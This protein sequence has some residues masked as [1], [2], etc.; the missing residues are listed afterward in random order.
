M[1]GQIDPESFTVIRLFSGGL[2]LLLLIRFR[3]PQA[4]IRGS[5]KGGLSLFLYAYLFSIA[6]VQLGAGMGAL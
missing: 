2:F 1:E 6:Y 3:N 4:A 5:W